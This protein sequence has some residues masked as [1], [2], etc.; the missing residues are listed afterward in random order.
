MRRLRIC[1]VIIL[2]CS[3]LLFGYCKIRQIQREDRI[4]PVIQ[5]NDKEIKVSINDGEEAL[6]K[7]VIAKDA[8][9]GDVSDSLLIDNISDFLEDGSRFVTIAA[10][11]QNE[12]VAKAVR[13]IS[14]SDY[15]RPSFDF[16]QPMRFLEGDADYLSYITAS[17]NID[18]DLS[19]MIRFSDE[20]QITADKAGEYQAEAEVRNSMGDTISL[21]FTLEVLAAEDYNKEPM[22]YLKHYVKYIK[23][24][25]HVDYKANL[26][27]ITINGRKYK[28]T[29]GEEIENDSVGRDKIRVD[30]DEVKYNTPGV[31][32]A[33]YSLTIGDEEEESEKEPIRGT[34]RLVVVVEE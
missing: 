16:T 30:D 7:G 26:D 27:Y 28:L 2:L 17:D 24:G 22:I 5:M 4:P 33:V 13:K 3:I 20:T 14:Y 11:D 1:S 21:P 18:G 15:E 9:D 12:N 23:K 31:Y 25:K 6:L 29:D 19:G 8:K 32:E 34:V 10:F